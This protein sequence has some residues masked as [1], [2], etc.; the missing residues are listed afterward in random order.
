M[1]LKRWDS[2]LGT[3]FAR[4]HDETNRLFGHIGRGD[5]TWRLFAYSY[6][7]VNIWE[8]DGNVYAEAELPGMQQDQLEVYVTDGN[9]LTIQGERRPGDMQQGVWHRQERGFG[10]FSRVLALPVAI[11]AN[12]VEA[13][14]ERGVLHITL[15]KSAIARAKQIAVKGE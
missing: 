7:P 4:L 5:S 12:Q 6:P 2:D 10:K 13:R 1:L 14:C 11:D 15:P 9:E 8:D 3:T